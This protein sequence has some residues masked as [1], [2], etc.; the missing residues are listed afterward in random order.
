MSY[1]NGY[2]KLGKVIEKFKVIHQK[3]ENIMV[4]K[5]VSQEQSIKQVVDKEPTVGDLSS[6]EY[7][8]KTRGKNYVRKDYESGT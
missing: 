4:K 2:S 7:E 1:Y 6:G 8:A 5:I 3:R